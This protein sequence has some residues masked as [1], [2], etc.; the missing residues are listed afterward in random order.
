VFCPAG[1]LAVIGT[2]VGLYVSIPIVYPFAAPHSTGKWAASIVLVFMFLFAFLFAR[3][4]CR[5]SEKR[6]RKKKFEAI[7]KQV[8]IHQEAL[9]TK[10]GAQHIELSAPWVK[11]L[12][13]EM[14][15]DVYVTF[16]APVDVLQFEEL[17]KEIEAITGMKVHLYSSIG[18]QR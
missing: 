16:T 2:H 8:L 4:G 11:E 3:F 14:R 9:R 5:W 13:D 7:R 17:R 18:G 15:V 1:I 6:E 10:Y 12:S